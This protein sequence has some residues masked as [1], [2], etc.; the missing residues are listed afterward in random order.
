MEFKFSMG[1]EVWFLRSVFARSDT[2]IERMMRETD[3]ILSV[4]YNLRDGSRNFETDLYETPEALIRGIFEGSDMKEHIDKVS[5][6]LQKLLRPAG[7]EPIG[8]G[9]F[10]AEFQTPKSYSPPK[11]GPVTAYSKF[12][13]GA[14]YTIQ[15]SIGYNPDKS[16]PCAGCGK[17]IYGLSHIT[18]VDLFCEECWREATSE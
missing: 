6:N 1:Q 11:Y 12:D 2:I 16:K 9:D 7:G 13:D 18:G 15:C 10:V 14:W 3:D 4:E 8:T 5:S 17:E